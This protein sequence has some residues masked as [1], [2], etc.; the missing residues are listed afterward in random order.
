MNNVKRSAWFCPSCQSMHAPHCDTCPNQADAVATKVM[1]RS[2]PV[3][4][5]TTPRGRLL[6]RDDGFAGLPEHLQAN[7]R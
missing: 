1:P 5:A 4:V 7:C 3:F 2:Y 6:T